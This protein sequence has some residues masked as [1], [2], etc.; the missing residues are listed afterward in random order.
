MTGYV[1]CLSICPQQTFTHYDHL[2]NY[3]LHFTLKKNPS[4]DPQIDPA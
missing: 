2:P 1:K 4:L 3:Y